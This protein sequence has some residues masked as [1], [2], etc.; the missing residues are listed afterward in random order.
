M[1]ALLRES[2]LLLL[3]SRS[4]GF[5]IVLIEAQAMGLSCYASDTVPKETDR[6]GVTFLPLS[7]GPEAWAD[8]ILRDRRYEQKKPCDC[9]PFSAA[10]FAEQFPV[11]Y[12]TPIH[13]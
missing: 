10:A 12:E 9:S 3:P 2:T 8:A 11:L 4:E 5:G 1:P 6:G 7:A 13:S